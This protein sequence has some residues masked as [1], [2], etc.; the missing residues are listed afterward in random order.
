MLL[1]LVLAWHLQIKCK[2]LLKIVIKKHN[3]FKIQRLELWEVFCP[4]TTNGLLVVIFNLPPLHPF[5][6]MLENFSF[7]K[8]S[9]YDCDHRNKNHV[10]IFI[11]QI[12]GMKGCFFYPLVSVVNWVGDGMDPL[13]EVPWPLCVNLHQGCPIL[14]LEGWHLTVFIALACLP[15]SYKYCSWNHSIGHSFTV[16]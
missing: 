14:L 12:L 3:F 13:Q 1:L 2:S 9:R 10:C 6:R 7:T 4:L 5:Q 16:V 11:S 8:Y 15:K